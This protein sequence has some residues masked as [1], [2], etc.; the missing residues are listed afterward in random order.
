MTRMQS[1]AAT[2]RSALPILLVL[3]GAAPASAQM[4]AITA[5]TPARGATDGG[6]TVEIL[7]NGWLA[8]FGPTTVTMLP[9]GPQP[10]NVVVEAPNRLTFVTPPRPAGTVTVRVVSNA[11]TRDIP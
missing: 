2:L 5:R 8:T 1:A 4:A 9:A 10:T 7:V 3:S 6:T 11:T